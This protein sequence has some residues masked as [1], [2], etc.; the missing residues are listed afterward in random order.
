MV[1][2]Q[3]LLQE[4][5]GDIMRGIGAAAKAVAPG[6]VQKFDAVAEPFKAFGERQP[7]TALKKELKDKFYR[8]FNLKTI[9]LQSPKTLPKDK[10]GLVR[11][12]IPFTAERFKAVSAVTPGSPAGI[13]GGFEQ[14]EQ[15]NAILTR[16]PD[17]TY[18]VEIRDQSNVEVVGEKGKEVSTKKDWDQL[19]TSSGL[20]PTP[21]VKALARWITA[22]IKN[23]GEEGVKELYADE[24]GGAKPS[25][26]LYT[27]TSFLVDYLGKRSDEQVDADNIKKVRELLKQEQII[28]ES[29]RAQKSQLN[30][31]LDSYNMRY[32]VSINKGN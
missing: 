8:V 30:F 10:S 29:V 14:A 16:K 26:N 28:K 20:G 24:L 1:S 23:Y 32:E 11:I 27:L 3:E 19:Y 13:E 12:V 31:L 4:T 2:Q 17:G 21:P 15:Y 18:G 9:K 7:T 22:T 6:L 25:S 5:F